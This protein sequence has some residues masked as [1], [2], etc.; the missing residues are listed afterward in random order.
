MSWSQSKGRKVERP[1]GESQGGGEKEERGRK[2]TGVSTSG[3]QGGN[4]GGKLQCKRRII[5]KGEQHL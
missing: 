2:K 3:K 1:E 4:F 5:I